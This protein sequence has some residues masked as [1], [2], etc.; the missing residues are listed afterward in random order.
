MM[1]C[2]AI[3]FALLCH[4]A[5]CQ[6]RQ[7]AVS[8][9]NTEYL[10]PDTDS[11]E[12]TDDIW[13]NTYFNIDWSNTFTH[14]TRPLNLDLDDPPP[15]NLD[16]LT[17]QLSCVI[18]DMRVLSDAGKHNYTVKEL[19][20]L[21]QFAKVTKWL[22]RPYIAVKVDRAFLPG[23]EK[24]KLGLTC[25]I[26]YEVFFQ[27]FWQNSWGNNAEVV[28]D[29]YLL[30]IFYTRLRA[31]I[32][33]RFFLNLETLAQLYGWDLHAGLPIP[34]EVGCPIEIYNA[35]FLKDQV[36]T[37]D[38]DYYATTADN[39]NAAGT[40]TNLE[41]L[42]AR[43]G[44]DSQKIWWRGRAEGDKFSKFLGRTMS[45]TENFQC[46]LE[47][48]CHLD[49]D[50]TQTG[51]R[52]A[53][54]LGTNRLVL[55]SR[56][57]YFALTALANI[58]DQLSN[59]Y[60]AIKG[61]AIRATLDTFNIDDF[62]PQKNQ[63]FSLRNVISGCGTVFALIGGFTPIASGFVGG[64]SAVVGALGG[65]LSSE[66]AQATDPLAT[67]KTF[68]PKVEEIYA[69]F[70]SSLNNATTA[71][72]D[73]G[74]VGNATIFDLMR[75]GS[76]VD[77]RILSRVSSVETQLKIEILSRS[78]DALWKT[79]PSNKTYV[80]F[81]DLQDDPSTKAKCLDDTDG[82][83][84]LRYCDD[85]GVYYAYNYVEDGNLEGH[86]DYPWGADKLQGIDIDMRVSLH[87]KDFH[88]IT[89]D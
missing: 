2:F 23:I 62:Y 55:Q 13:R 67:Q 20:G 70:V 7:I 35:R 37:C 9:R 14:Q 66:I 86:L 38:S 3:Y 32:Q 58:N 54:A 46:S 6:I 24:T 44:A 36:E 8:V 1:L 25:G 76:W 88:A 51:S 50:C 34:F 73:G 31:D 48:R 82:P 65:L 75:N 71:L 45:A 4:S 19:Q 18:N 87:S 56:W 21:Q 85:G 72:F 22:A 52:K 68:A 79:G 16:A 77:S 33:Y 15:E 63:Q 64:A 10:I 42:W 60:V 61:A 80:L 5:T 59:Q 12:S 43:T 57:G 39:W 74:K 81:V 78:I 29:P 53:L 26:L 30:S 11:D 41:K 28:E 40:D 84:E 27:R 83:L 47:S 69:K 89:N 49:L 17:L